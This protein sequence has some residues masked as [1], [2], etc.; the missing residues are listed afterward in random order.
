MRSEGGARCARQEGEMRSA[1]VRDALGGS[2]G[3][4]SEDEEEQ[5][6]QNYLDR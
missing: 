1:G 4:R 6:G 2:A 5:Y 3:K